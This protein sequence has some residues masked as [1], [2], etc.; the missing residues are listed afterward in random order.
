M[1]DL[2][3]F[4]EDNLR[5]FMSGFEVCYNSALFSIAPM[6]FISSVYDA[7]HVHVS[8]QLH[9][10]MFVNSNSVYAAMCI[11]CRSSFR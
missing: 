3:P 6:M 8:S 5:N 7:I 2:A 4:V 9:I 10:K 1:D 11:L